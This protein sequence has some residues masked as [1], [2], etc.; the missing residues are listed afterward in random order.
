MKCQECRSVMFAMKDFY[1]CDNCDL[2]EEG[3]PTLGWMRF[4]YGAH[5]WGD[6]NWSSGY[7]KTVELCKEQCFV[8]FM[9]KELKYIPGLSKKNYPNNAI[10]SLL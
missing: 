8:E 2:K 6:G 3:V 4:S 5:C 1:Y 7:S 9:E 10:N